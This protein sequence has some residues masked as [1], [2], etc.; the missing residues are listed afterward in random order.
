MMG[1]CVKYTSKYSSV[2]V[3]YSL[4]ETNIGLGLAAGIQ[5]GQCEYKRTFSG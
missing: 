5:Q 2:S 1:A 3:Y 4:L